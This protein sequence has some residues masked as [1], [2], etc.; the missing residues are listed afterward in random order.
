M[1]YHVATIHKGAYG[2]FSK[3]EEEWAELCDAHFQG[4]RVLELCEL[5]D[6]VGAIE[7]YV[8]QHFDMDLSDILKMMEMTREAFESGERK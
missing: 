5:A 2:E 1:G 8:R 6:L 4:A 3:L 7:G